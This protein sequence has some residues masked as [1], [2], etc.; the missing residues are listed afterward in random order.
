MNPLEKPF[1]FGK[2]RTKGRARVTPPKRL[3]WVAV[4][5]GRWRIA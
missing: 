5:G 1:V 4:P 2:D 3:F